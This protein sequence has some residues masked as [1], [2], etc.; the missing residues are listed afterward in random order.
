MLKRVH[1]K[2]FKSLA[3]VEVHL[4]P[5]SVLFGANARGKSNFLDALQLLSKIA[6]SEVLGDAFDP[7]CRG[8]PIELFTMMPEGIEEMLRHSQLSFSIEA[9]IQ[10]SDTVVNT[11]NQQIQEVYALNGGDFQSG[12][13]PALVRE[14]NLRYH[15]E[16]EI[17]PEAG[18]LRIAREHLTAL[19]S[20]GVP[21]DG[22]EPFIERQGN[23]LHLRFEGR[24]HLHD[25][26]LFLNHAVLSMSLHPPHC[27]HIMAARQ[28]FKGWQF[29]YF[30]PREHMRKP[31]SLGEYHRIGPMGEDIPGFL[32]TLKA[33]SPKRFKSIEKALRLLIPNVDGIE[34][35][36]NSFGDI[37]LYIRE[38]GIAISARVL[39]EGT[40]R[41]LGMLCL[42]ASEHD[43]PTLVGLEEPENGVHPRRIQ[44][45]AELLK[46][47]EIIGQTQ[48]IVTTH[49]SILTD[50]ISDE[51][52][53]VVRKTDGQTRIDP[54][55]SWGPLW[56]RDVAEY[57]LS[58][59]YEELPV[60]DRILRG[61]FD[62]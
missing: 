9:D 51:S 15:I 6:T 49:S 29:F 20:E 62:A 57:E 10:L 54:L 48:Y 11:V 23:E 16:I 46:T 45:I 30:E 17:L 59:D 26:G 50:L 14:R 41:M 38:N 12:K 43:V 25:R 39:S 7:P 31:S 61:D 28:E 60:S 33:T 13:G 42:I 22:R 8:K 34:V 19:D 37:D 58:D 18:R 55:T 40:L 56:H 36:L 1:I 32:Y 21:I 27:P 2:G 24:P 5:L 52:L 53:S 47:Q 3:D 44:L 4:E 35:D